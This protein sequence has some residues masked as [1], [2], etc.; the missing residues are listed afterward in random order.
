MH[1][2][3]QHNASAGSRVP[4]IAR[5]DWASHPNYPQQA[6]L[7]GSHRNFRRVS[8]YLISSA[9]SVIDPSREADRS[10]QAGRSWQARQL[11]RLRDLFVQWKGAM[12]SHEAY[13]EGKLYPYLEAR[14]GVSMAELREQHEA[15]VPLERAALDAWAAREREALIGALEGHDRALD[16]HLQQEED[17]VIPLLL[18]M[19]PTEFDAYYRGSINAL[20]RALADGGGAAGKSKSG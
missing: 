10:R 11:R 6:L 16:A 3:K 7:L 2:A 13:E 12:R 17:M 5:E 1:E 19:P 20:L 4:Q 15:L 18:A 9:R 14:Y 8:Q